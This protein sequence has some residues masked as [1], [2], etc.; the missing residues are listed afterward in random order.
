M[1]ISTGFRIF[2]ALA[3]TASLTA[4]FIAC[5]GS[6]DQDVISQ[7]AGADT[8]VA[9]TYVP[10]SAPVDS[11]PKDSGPKDSGPQYDA[12]PPTVL[13]GGDLYEGGIPCVAGGLAEEEIND[14]PD[15]ANPL[16]PADASCVSPGC[17]RCG[18]IFQ[19]DP[20]AGGDGGAE[21]E[22]VS[23]D[24]HSS[25]KSF[26]LQFAG[27][28]TMTVT[29]GNQGPF[30]IN[31]SSSPTLPFVRDET[32]FVKVSSNSGKRTPWRVTLFEV[33]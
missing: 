33:Q 3:A 1:R 8:S 4:A 32:Y 26:F 29:V 11:G 21:V 6:D 20:D 25:A 13:D 17:T 30:V 14:E 12:G 2:S 10:D 28:I 15:A 19:S 23:F 18:I 22:Y 27:D 7:D 24:I 31:Q 16:D 9:D 5:S